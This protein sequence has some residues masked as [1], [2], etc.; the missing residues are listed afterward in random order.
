[1]KEILTQTEQ[2]L[3]EKKFN[4][5]YSVV[6]KLAQYFGNAKAAVD[7]EICEVDSFGFLIKC[8]VLT[9]EI[10]KRIAKTKRKFW[11]NLILEQ[12]IR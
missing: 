2:D 9:D 5:D 4:S 7:S 12:R 6:V 10:M 3:L 8:M 11:L 1:M